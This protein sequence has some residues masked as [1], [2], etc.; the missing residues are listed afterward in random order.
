MI[1][2]RLRLG[3]RHVERALF[4]PL[5]DLFRIIREEHDE[6]RHAEKDDIPRRVVVST[7]FGRVR[8][9]VCSVLL[10][11]RGS[12]FFRRRGMRRRVVVVAL[13]HERVRGAW[14]QFPIISASIGRGKETDGCKRKETKS[15]FQ[16]TLLDL[17]ARDFALIRNE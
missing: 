17:E 2:A 1:R 9:G 8:R 14:G 6:N 5:L 11:I 16:F 10:P 13:L 12:H 7:L 4:L 3:V 15:F